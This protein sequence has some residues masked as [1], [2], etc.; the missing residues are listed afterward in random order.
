V[1]RKSTIETQLLLPLLLPSVVT[2]FIGGLLTLNT[3]VYFVVTG[4]L[5][6][7]AA[8]L[9]IFK[10]TADRRDVRRMQLGPTA[11]VGAGAGF[12]SGLTGVGGGVFVVPVLIG[13]GWVSPR[14]AAAIAPI[15]SL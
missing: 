11:A 15:H 2:A 13:L 1:P 6:L 7:A 3:R 4:L 12:V 5:L 10:R 9:M 8:L 14:R